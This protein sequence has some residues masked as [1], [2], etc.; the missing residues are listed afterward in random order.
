MR[1]LIVIL[2]LILA[3]MSYSPSHPGIRGE[4]GRHDGKEEISESI[5][6]IE[7]LGKAAVSCPAL[8]TSGHAVLSTGGNILPAAPQAPQTKRRTST[9]RSFFIR[10]GKVIDANNF[11]PFFSVVFLKESGCLSCERYIFS[12]CFL[13][14]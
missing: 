8:S 14:L 10:D 5:R 1:S 7:A 2:E 13:R 4:A 9:G 3:F 12:I 6:G 11:T